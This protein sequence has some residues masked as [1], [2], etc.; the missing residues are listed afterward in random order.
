MS[1]NPHIAEPHS[2]LDALMIQALRRY[3]E[4]SPQTINSEITQ[5]LLDLANEVVD[6]VNQH[7][8]HSKGRDQSLRVDVQPYISQT[9]ARPIQDNVMVAGLLAHYSI[10][11]GSQ[12]K[13]GVYTPRYFRLLNQWLWH[14]ISGGSGRIQLRVPDD[15]TATSPITGMPE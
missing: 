10:Q 15:P 7:P 5:L 14:E 8:Y 11:Q 1:Q 6:E 2:P 12:F 3:G 13:A 9:D 4:F